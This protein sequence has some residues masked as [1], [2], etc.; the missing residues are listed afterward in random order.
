MSDVGFVSPVDVLPATATVV[1]ADGTAIGVDVLGAGAPVVLVGGAC[2]TR[3]ANHALAVLLSERFQVLNYDRR[4]RGAS[5]DTAPYAPE[6]EYEDLRAVIESA[7]GSAAVFGTSSGA[8]LA[9]RAAA[10]GVPV[11]RL[12]LWEP[13]FLVDDSRPAIPTD[14]AETARDLAARG[15]GDET[16]EYFLTAAVG[17]PSEFVASAKEG[18]FW[19]GMV[20]LAPTIAYDAE[21]MGQGSALPA[22]VLARV[23]VPTLV[24][25]GGG[26]PWIAASAD[27]T[28]TALVLGRRATLTGQTHDVDPAVLAPAVT[29]FLTETTASQS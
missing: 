16:I 19:P 17:L 11:T 27:A 25:D 12:A 9:L 4:G 15:R 29:R 24:L 14:Y 1:S 6:R 10:A 18:P 23:D 2:T 26:W 13:P 7:R 8:V 21:V 3:A 20:A 28:A 22:D 5:T